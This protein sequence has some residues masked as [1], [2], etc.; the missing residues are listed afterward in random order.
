VRSLS[1]FL[2]RMRSN[3]R[4]LGVSGPTLL[5][6]GMLVLAC[7]PT[8]REAKLSETVVE[9]ALARSLDQFLT[10]QADSGWDGTALVAEG[11]HIL[12][13]KG[14]GRLPRS[15]AV[16]P[17]TPFWIA[18]ISKQFGAVAILKLAEEHK[19]SLQ[20]SLPQFFANVPPDKRSI[21]LEQLLDHTGGLARNYAADGIVDRDSAVAAILSRPLAGPPGKRFV[22]SNDAY[23]LVAA[24]IEIVTKTPYEQYLGAHLLTP[25]GLRH[26]G[27]W[28][29]NE[30][31]EV[32]PIRG[33]IEDTADLRPNWGFRGGTG[34]FST[35]GDLYLWNE[36]LEQGRVISR[37]SVEMMRSAHVRSEKGVGVGYGW[38]VSRTPG[39]TPSVWTRGYEDFG[40]GAVL[41]TYPDEHMVI[42]LTSDAGLRDGVPV[43]HRLSM[44]LERRIFARP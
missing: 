3:R 8:G 27:F 21:R 24:I 6:A 18:S 25:A 28:G 17:V 20:D 22:Y 23:N 43:S 26:T 40:H 42:A 44:Q 41:A 33:A 31:P 9:G 32:A 37:K 35:A 38:F 4:P 2:F 11:G 39:G 19:L 10:E 5:G 16:T 15:G 7:N 30:H 14:Y 34:M 12:L 36:A 1:R 13:N 29:P